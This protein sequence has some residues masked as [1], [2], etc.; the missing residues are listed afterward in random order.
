M[1]TKVTVIVD[2]IGQDGLEGEWG[3]SLLVEY[4]NKKLLADTGSS[5]LFVTNLKELGYNIEDIDY[6]T[7]SHAHY[8]HSNG[9]PAFFKLNKTASFYLREGTKPNCYKKGKLLKFIPYNIYIGIPKKLTTEYS[10]RIKYVSGDYKLCE[11]V[12]LIPHKTKGLEKIGER[13]KMYQK[14][15]KGYVFDDYCHEQSLVLDTE[16]GLVIINCCSHGG[17]ANIINE[18]AETFPDK[19]VYGIIGGFHL[20]NKTDEE[21]RA[22][23]RKVRDTGI[24]FVCTG[25]CTKEKAYGIL[26]EELGDIASL[27][28]V[29][30]VMEF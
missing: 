14:T 15:E 26:H 25:H 28:H 9:M 11:G 6:G 12:Y 10:D 1:K 3:L 29:G 23:A 27:M 22:F 18:V 4:G 17:A 2:N 7:L 24:S 21:V 8:D 19:K 16:K 30:M 13:E 5:D 20:F